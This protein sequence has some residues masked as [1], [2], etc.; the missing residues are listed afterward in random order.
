M[1]ATAAE[2]ECPRCTLLNP[3]GAL[4]CGACSETLSH[5]Y[6]CES[7][8]GFVLKARRVW[9]G[10]SDSCAS[11]SRSGMCVVVEGTRLAW[12]GCFDLLPESFSAWRVI[13]Y[14]DRASST[15]MPGLIDA[16]VHM[17]FDPR[18]DLHDQPPMS[19]SVQLA[20]LA[21]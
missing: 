7:E 3:P 8:G 17:E 20:Q 6:P 1:E 15:I 19:R 18:Y 11:D 9:D 21:K 12:V 13:D 2:V 14:F 16:H 5:C 4:Q 10:L